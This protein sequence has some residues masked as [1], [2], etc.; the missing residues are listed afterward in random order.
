MGKI[1][2]Y[3]RQQLAST[4]T[5]VVSQDRSGEMVGK[6][7]A[8]FGAVMVKRQDILDTAE[9]TKAYY[10]Y[11]AADSLQSAELQKKY[12][13]DPDLDPLSFGEEYGARTK[14]LAETFA[15]Q[16]PGRVQ[17][18]FGLLVD[19]QQAA[20]TITNNKWVINQQ[21]R[22]A[23]VDFQDLS[24]SSVGIAGE[25][26]SP[27]DYLKGREIY[28]AASESYRAVTTPKS[29]DSATKATLKQQAGAYWNN[30]V[31]F[32]NGGN[33][34]AFAES[35]RSNADVRE[36]LQ[37]DLG[38][39][40]FARLEKNLG[41]MIKEMGMYQGFQ[42]L[43]VDDK[44][45]VEKVQ[46]VYDP[47]NNY[48]LKEVSQELEEEINRRNYMVSTNKEGQNTPAIEQTNKNIQNLEVLKRISIYANDSSYA[49]DIDT[50]SQLDSEIRLAMAPYGSKKFKEVLAKVESDV[51]RK[52]AKQDTKY[53]WY[54]YLNPYVQGGQIWRAGQAAVTGVPMGI[55]AE[56]TEN[57]K[58][59]KTVS[60]YM[61][62]VYT[63][64][65][66]V[67]EA[68]E[69]KKLTYK[70][71]VNM[72]SK[73]G[74][75]SSVEK[76]DALT[77]TG[78]N[79]FTEGYDAFNDY[80]RAINLNT[81]TVES[82]RQLRDDIRNQMTETYSSRISAFGDAPTSSQKI[83]DTINQI[84]YEKNQQLHPEFMG[85]KIGDFVNVGGRSVEFMGFSGNTGRVQIKA[86]G[87]QKSLDN[88]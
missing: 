70:D 59:S 1:N 16:L 39:K 50:K 82:N 38:T 9:A 48:G 42:K 31:D 79:W 40:E 60:Q 37:T 14:V 21:N 56:K 33:P 86:K 53:P 3:Q 72:I 45:L 17:A 69:A 26:M 81:G 29:F 24:T 34:A 61:D 7:V 67:L 54:A 71:G 15:Q 8:D 49:S 88:L 27:D 4:R 23:L 10:K 74:L 46:K 36:K 35:I 87:L 73:I 85:V 51:G 66:R 78:K 5:Q 19:K 75:L 55:R 25:A 65:G 58:A 20:Q 76:Y 30:N 84:K 77:A 22:N 13:N 62:D 63:M 80:V 68:V 64:K 83:Q 11:A 52:T 47:N 18:K 32:R 2:E 44:N 57:I 28:L 12:M 6:D 41:T 43:L